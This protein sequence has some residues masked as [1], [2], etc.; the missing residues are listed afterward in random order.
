MK[1]SVPA[2]FGTQEAAQDACDL[3][4]KRKPYKLKVRLGR[5]KTWRIEARS[6]EGKRFFIRRQELIDTIEALSER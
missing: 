4:S 2:C 5:D 1:M 6:T 3:L